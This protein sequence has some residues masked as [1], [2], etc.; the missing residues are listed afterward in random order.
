MG[1]Y[2]DSVQMVLAQIDLKKWGVPV[3]HYL[4]NSVSTFFRGERADWA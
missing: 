1:I 4:N 3:K 2:R